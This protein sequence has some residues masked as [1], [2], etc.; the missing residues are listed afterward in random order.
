M[1]R[2]I[3]SGLKW[4]IVASSFNSIF[5]V[6]TVFGSIFLLFLT[7]LGIPKH[8][9]GILLSFLPFFG[10]VA[11]F[12]SDYVEYFGS[13]KTFLICFGIRKFV[14]LS[15]VLLPLII[16][17]FGKTAG[18]NFII[19]N[20]SLFAF[21]RAFGETGYYAWAKEFIPDNL[22][23]KYVAIQNIITNIAGIFAIS[24]GSYV[25]GKREGIEKYLF[26]IEIAFIFGIL[27]VYFMSFVPF[28]EPKR[29]KPSFNFKKVLRPLMDKNFL[30]FL[31]ALG[32]SLFGCSLM[33]FVPIFVREKLGFSS[34]LVVFLDNATIL[35]SILI[36]SIWGIIGDRF[37]GRPVIVLSL[38]F[39]SI[40]VFLWLT[41][42]RDM[43]SIINFIFLLY[44]LSG[45]TL[46]GRTVG[47]YRFLYASILKNVDVIYYTSIFYAWIGIFQG[48]S[49]IFAG[50]LLEKFKN[51][52]FLGRDFDIYSIIFLINLICQILAIIIYR[53]VKPDKDVKTRTLL[54]KLTNTFLIEK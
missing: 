26:L 21:L 36:V 30:Y 45:A 1:E 15:L 46:P 17:R 18:I 13:K 5:C 52:Y 44:F 4:S 12:L 20:I 50:Y 27:S 38:F 32:I 39:Y 19:F 16:D 40:V 9:I 37:G 10:V 6:L 49:P 22:R 41:L 29:Q 54:L 43:P 23:G 2:E 7:E 35:G 34:E 42:K 33:S 48:I 14:I 28:G 53:K 3:K 8:K 51:F 11:P 47:D 31:S 24:F 25:I